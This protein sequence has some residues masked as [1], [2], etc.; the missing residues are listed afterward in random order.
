MTQVALATLI[1][2]QQPGQPA[3]HREAAL[4]SLVPEALRVWQRRGDRSALKQ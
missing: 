3:K 2:S 4:C 1:W